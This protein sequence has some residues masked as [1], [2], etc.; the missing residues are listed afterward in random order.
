[1]PYFLLK[2]PAGLLP[3][4]CGSSFLRTGESGEMCEW[5]FTLWGENDL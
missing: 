5:E 1:M 2:T 4:A 3:S